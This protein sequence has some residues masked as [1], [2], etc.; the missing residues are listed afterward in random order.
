[1]RSLLLIIGL[2]FLVLSFISY[3]PY[4]RG[5]GEYTR[6]SGETGYYKELSIES[7][8]PVKKITEDKV[9]STQGAINKVTRT[10]SPGRK[11]G[12]VDH[13][14]KTPALKYPA[15]LISDGKNYSLLLELKTNK[16]GKVDKVKILE[17]SGY[18]DLDQHA[19]QQLKKEWRLAPLKTYRLPL[20]FKSL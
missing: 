6:L 4:P 7:Y 19:K 9:R 5:E 20:K 10:K 11:N 17:S 18:E 8:F 13:S 15:D 3:S 12:I 1:M 14:F 2:H 16:A